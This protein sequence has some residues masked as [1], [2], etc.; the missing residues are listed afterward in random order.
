MTSFFL[1]SFI[2]SAESKIKETQEKHIKLSKLG[3]KMKREKK[4]KGKKKLKGK[5]VSRFHPSQ[6]KKRAL[7]I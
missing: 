1:Q 2:I 6:R 7:W 5:G 4:P 3:K